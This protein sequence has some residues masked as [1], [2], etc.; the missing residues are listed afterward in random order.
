VYAEKVS[1]S[2]PPALLDFVEEY[3]IAR[4]IKSRSQV[5]EDALYVLR[6]RE[7]ELAYKGASAEVDPAWKAS[8]A[9]GLDD[10][11]W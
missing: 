7:L 9:D 5:I 1:I 10:E 4:G 3:R 6:E 8:V 2:L 11:A